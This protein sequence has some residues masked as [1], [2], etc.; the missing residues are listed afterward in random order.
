MVRRM[1]K[2]TEG[3]GIAA[4][5]RALVRAL[6][7]GPIAMGCLAG[8]GIGPGQAWAEEAPLGVEIVTT[9]QSVNVVPIVMTG[10][11]E[12]VES[13]SASFRTGGAVQSI[14]VSVGDRVA[15]GQEL[16]RLDATQVQAGVSSAEAGLRGADAALL[17]AELNHD[18]VAALVGRGTAT[19]AD[20]DAAVEAL[21]AAQ[22]GRDQAELR[23]DKAASALDDSVLRATAAAIVTAREAE[24][25]QVVGSGQAVLELA[26]QAGREAVFMA[27]DGPVL[28]SFLGQTIAL[29][30]LDAPEAAPMTAVITEIAP[31]VEART[32]AVEVRA[33]LAAV[34]G[35][36]PLLG[37]AVVGRS[38]LPLGL[39][40]RL[41]WTALTATAEG[42][43]VWVVD[44]A[45][46]VALRQV[47][48]TRY[49]TGVVI[50]GEGLAAGEQV[51]G[52]GSHMLYPGRR[53]VALAGVS[54]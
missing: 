42:P 27:P 52:Q 53:V 29:T 9:A 13:H 10:T 5:V 14:S 50:V 21:A 37:E 34:P 2:A 15:A 49:L 33:T 1:D 22:A 41:P 11:L 26:G 20:L 40:V 31:I 6:V 28:D 3:G 30:R 18:R 12:A 4:A 46:Q 43:A 23:R 19:Q 25:G 7:L 51:V 8:S 16:A 45:G 47:V 39:G 17:Q 35:D 44:S 24:P 36:D 48:V 32:G 38:A 54:Q